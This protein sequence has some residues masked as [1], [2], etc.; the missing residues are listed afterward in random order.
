ME[1]AESATEY[2]KTQPNRMGIDVM[3]KQ[4]TMCS[5]ESLMVEVKQQRTSEAR[6]STVKTEELD[7]LT[8][9]GRFHPNP[10]F[11]DY[12]LDSLALLKIKSHNKTL[13]RS[14]SDLKERVLEQINAPEMSFS[15]ILHLKK[16]SKYVEIR[17]NRCEKFSQWFA[18]QDESKVVED[19]NYE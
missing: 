5:Y 15:Y 11:G 14:I 19:E 17:C 4:K 16:D 3:L 1:S 7:R 12:I 6:L 13:F 9:S 10:N 2:L 8:R 18:T